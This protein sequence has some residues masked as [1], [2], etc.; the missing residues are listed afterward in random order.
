MP[1][2]QRRLSWHTLGGLGLLGVALLLPAVA[3]AQTPD[4]SASPVVA[5]ETASAPVVPEASPRP[6]LLADLSPGLSA[7]VL[8]RAGDKLSDGT[9]FSPKNDFTTYL[10]LNARE[11]FLLVGHEIAWGRDALG[12]RLTRLFFRDGQVVSGRLWASGMHNNCAG[13][14][15]P[16]KT[17][18]TCEEFPHDV[19]PGDNG[20][21]RRTA[22]LRRRLND[23]HPLASWGWVYEVNPFGG[24]P[25]G[26]AQRR[27]ALGR[28]S[29]ESAVVVGDREVYLT[30][31]FEPG[32]LYKFVASKPR[33]LSQGQLYAYVRAESR[34]LPIIDTVNA[35]HAAEVAGATPFNR[36]EDIQLGP[37]RQLYIAE[38]GHPDWNDR[39]GRILKL[40]PRTNRMKVF[41]EG[42]G[43]L[44]AQPD[45]LSFDR[46]GNLYVCEDQ[47]KE[48]LRVFGL[49]ELL[50]RDAK[51]R[52]ARLA[53]FPDGAEPTGPSWSPDGQTMYLSVLWG[54]KSGLL[55]LRGF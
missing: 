47:Y 24:T 21:A 55:A 17:I 48:N 23:K 51:G 8:L 35:H 33:D 18:L 2:H 34:W 42:D 16:W 54:D 3:G 38:T 53:A 10:P 13:T 31:D 1:N 52:W 5:T 4:S 32:Y 39:Y 25:A 7:K 6:S 26:Q 19:Y 40:D 49:N 44:L 9:L 12:G 30:E 41:V 37:D 50:R 15:T 11:G 14:L 22:Y 45:N 36:L 27:M 20:K 29:H 43:T 46:A 28:F